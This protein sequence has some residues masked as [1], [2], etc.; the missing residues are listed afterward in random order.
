M[1]KFVK[2]TALT[3]V[4][5]LT[6]LPVTESMA[7]RYYVHKP[8]TRPAQV[9]GNNQTGAWAVGCGAASVAALMIGTA[10][11]NGANDKKL[12]R[13]LT[14]NEAGWASA[15]CPVLLPWALIVQAVCPD[16][17]ATVAIATYAYRYQQKVRVVGDW[18]QF[19][20]AYGEACRTGKLPRPFV[21]FLRE[22]GL[23]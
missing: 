2:L 7:H 3:V 19:T 22:N 5:M 21:Q 12:R 20:N 16:N 6:A 13:Q 14:L 23:A 9:Q 11:A 17:K 1:R 8:K 18:S 10:V 15:A 4:A